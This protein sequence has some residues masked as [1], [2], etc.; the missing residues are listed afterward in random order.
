MEVSNKVT[1]QI[2]QEKREQLFLTSLEITQILLGEMYS[3]KSLDGLFS[4]VKKHYQ[5]RERFIGQTA[6]HP[7][8]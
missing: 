6:T 8:P 7:H 4:L 1:G 5:D 3:E 2:S